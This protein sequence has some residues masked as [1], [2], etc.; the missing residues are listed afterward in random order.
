MPNYKFNNNKINRYNKFDYFSQDKFNGLIIYN[1]KLIAN[2]I[3][4]KN[5]GYFIF[6]VKV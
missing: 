6:K 1:K 3:F 2:F 4:S 5:F